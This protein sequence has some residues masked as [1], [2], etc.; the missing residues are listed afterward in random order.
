MGIYIDVDSALQEKGKIPFGECA[1]L[2]RGCSGLL[3]QH[4]YRC[5]TRMGAGCY[6]REM[7]DNAV[8]E[9]V[10]Y[11]ASSRLMTTGNF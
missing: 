9:V 6:N 11:P 8:R 4:G 7:L 10:I 2:G 5:E 3:P 1:Y